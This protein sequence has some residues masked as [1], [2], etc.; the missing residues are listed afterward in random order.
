MKPLIHSRAIVV[1]V[2]LALATLGI[3]ALG[4]RAHAVSSA[5]SGSYDYAEALQD[6]MAFY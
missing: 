1:L 5:A 3:V 4:P 2:A 6:S